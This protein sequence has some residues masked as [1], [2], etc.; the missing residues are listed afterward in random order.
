MESSKTEGASTVAAQLPDKG[1]R[2]AQAAYS[3]AKAGTFV[4]PEDGA[5]RLAAQCDT[6]V[7]GL[8][9]EIEAADH[10]TKVTGFPNLPS[11]K[12]LTKGFSAKGQ[13]YIDTLKAFVQTALQY[14]AAY[15]AA[16]K[17]F[18]EAD[19]ANQAAIKYATEQLQG[20]A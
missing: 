1:Q 7:D 8:I 2:D 10:L 18:T 5:K 19:A 6:L 16:G 9:D 14:K 3:A 17:Q 15:L 20:N 11:G 12:A 13:E 4:M